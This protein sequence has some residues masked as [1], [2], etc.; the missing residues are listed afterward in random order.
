MPEVDYA[1]TL[2][3]RIMATPR[4]IE[5]NGVNMTYDEV[6]EL[7]RKLEGWKEIILPKKT[8][9]YEQGLEEKELNFEYEPGF[10]RDRT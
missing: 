4:V 1:C 9:Y 2:E 8:F 5:V 6:E 3:K 7:Q 10:K